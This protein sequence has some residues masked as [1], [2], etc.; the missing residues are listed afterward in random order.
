MQGTIGYAKCVDTLNNLC[1][2]YVNATY[3]T[4]GSSVGCT[5]NSVG[6]IQES[7]V[8]YG[9]SGSPYVDTLYTTD[10]TRLKDSSV[11]HGNLLPSTGVWLASR[12]IS[13][14]TNYTNFRP[15]AMKTSV[16]DVFGPLMSTCSIINT[17]QKNESSCVE[18][19]MVV[20]SLTPDIK[21]IEGAGTSTNP[22]KITK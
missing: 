2:E 10:E 13:S 6:K 15:R 21:I 5:S 19:L 20:I 18:G 7:Q 11:L 22:Y 4:S 9:V 3:A 8:V 17:G 16:D 14:G 12:F 1:N